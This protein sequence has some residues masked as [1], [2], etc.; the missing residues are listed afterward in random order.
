ML[1]AKTLANRDLVEIT[2]VAHETKGRLDFIAAHVEGSPAVFM[3][4]AIID[5]LKPRIGCTVRARIIDHGTHYD[6]EEP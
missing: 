6:L 3:S 2:P 1:T 4:S 5:K